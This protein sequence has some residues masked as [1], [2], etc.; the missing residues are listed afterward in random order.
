MKNTNEMEC[1]KTTIKGNEVILTVG[2][3]SDIDKIKTFAELCY[4]EG[5]LECKRC[6]NI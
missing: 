3:I 4:K 6:M 1:L 2:T 5:Y